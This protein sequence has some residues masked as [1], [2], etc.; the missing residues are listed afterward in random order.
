MP[1]R[2]PGAIDASYADHVEIVDALARRDREAV[3]AAFR[4]HLTRIY[5]TTKELLALHAR[6]VGRRQQR[7]TKGRSGMSRIAE[8]EVRNLCM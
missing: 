2:E 1:C 8:R 5:D 7:E 4:H 3:V 6:R